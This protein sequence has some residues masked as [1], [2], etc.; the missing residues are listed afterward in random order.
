MSADVVT[1]I[2]LVKMKMR[3]EKSGKLKNS[4]RLLRLD[5]L[6]V[7]EHI[8]A[9]LAED[10]FFFLNKINEYISFAKESK[11]GRRTFMKLIRHMESQESQKEFMKFIANT[12]Y[13]ERAL[14]E[15]KEEQ[16]FLLEKMIEFEE[17]ETDREGFS[18][19]HRI[20]CYILIIMS[21]LCQADF[22]QLPQIM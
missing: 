18:Q 2:E 10:N 6:D 9:G 13:E 21:R 14:I 11:E 20:E 19:R 4:N 17:S 8:L 22:H 5:D 12:V 15:E 16:L 7:G 3:L 1:K